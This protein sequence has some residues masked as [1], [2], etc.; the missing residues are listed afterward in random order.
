MNIEQAHVAKH[1]YDGLGTAPTPLLEVVPDSE[2][3]M[4]HIICRVRF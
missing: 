3:E 4:M 2:Y 1:H